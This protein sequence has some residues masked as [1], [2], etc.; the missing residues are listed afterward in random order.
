MVEKFG[1]FV[2]PTLLHFIHILSIFYFIDLQYLKWFIHN[3]A[4]SVQS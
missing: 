4:Y 1:Y 2:I 3:Y